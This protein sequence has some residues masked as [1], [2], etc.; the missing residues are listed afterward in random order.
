MSAYEVCAGVIN[1]LNEELPPDVIIVN[2]ANADMVG[3]T[4]SMPSIIKAVE[5]VDQCC[6]KIIDATLGLGGSLLITADHGNAERTWNVETN[7]PDTAHTT[8]DVSLH[9]VGECWRTCSLRSGGILADIAPTMLQMIAV[10]KPQE[11]T[12]NSLIQ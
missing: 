9:L 7:S 6:G 12:G 5:V 8:F 10:Q 2:F 3:H 11:M 4:G 1:S